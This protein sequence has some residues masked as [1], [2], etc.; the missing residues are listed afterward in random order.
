M[1]HTTGIFLAQALFPPGSTDSLG[2]V[3]PKVELHGSRIHSKDD[4]VVISSKSDSL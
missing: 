1:L 2:E 3:D 4:E